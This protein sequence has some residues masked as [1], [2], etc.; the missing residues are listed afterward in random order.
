MYVYKIHMYSQTSNSKQFEITIHASRVR[1][2]ACR[3]PLSF[4]QSKWNSI[5][6]FSMYRVRYP[7]VWE[8][9]MMK[10]KIISASAFLDAI[11]RRHTLDVGEQSLVYVAGRMESHRKDTD[12]EALKGELNLTSHSS[13]PGEFTCV[14]TQRARLAFT[15]LT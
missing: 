4:L 3:L 5:P 14:N 8:E 9:K 7:L 1:L 12:L 2:S 13:L 11:V 6:K 15:A 10:V